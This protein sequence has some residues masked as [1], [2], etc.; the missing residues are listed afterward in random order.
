MWREKY[1]NYVIGYDILVMT[2]EEL[3]FVVQTFFK[4]IECVIAKNRASR[5]RFDESIKRTK[6]LDLGIAQL[7][8]IEKKKT[9]TT[10]HVS[11]SWS[12]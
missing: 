7:R 4:N 10:Q 11:V 12:L 1:D 9:N 3:D 6:L 8:A 5:D 2:N